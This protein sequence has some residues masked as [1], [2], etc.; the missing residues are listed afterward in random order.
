MKKKKIWALIICIVLFVLASLSVLFL[1]RNGK[2]KTVGEKGTETEANTDENTEVLLSFD[3]YE[4]ITKA[5]L[6]IGNQFGETKI[7]TE[8]AFITE[9]KGSWMIRP[10]GDYG[11]E[12]YYPYF[13]LRCTESSFAKSDFE[14][15]DKL[16]LDVYNDSDE[17]IEMECILSATNA[18]D[19][20][21]SGETTTWTLKPNA[22]TACEYDLSGEEYS[23]ALDLTEARYMN[24]TILS[25]KESKEDTVP[26]LYLDN[27]R[28]H[29]SGE[30]REH[31][32]FACNF[33]ETVTFETVSERYL[34]NA[35][36]VGSNKVSLSRAA[37][38]NSVIGAQ[39][40][41]FG[42]Y[43][44]QGTVQGA[45]W[46]A[47]TM[48]Y[49][50]EL[51][52][53]TIISCKVYVAADEAEFG[54]ATY[55]LEPSGCSVFNGKLKF[56]CWETV[57]FELQKAADSTWFFLNFDD[58]EGSSMFGGTTVTY[59]M[60]NFRILSKPEADFTEGVDL[61]EPDRKSVV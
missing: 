29:I 40:E 59:F 31:E 28:G 17:V 51:P 9:G 10:Q 48:R 16:L 52:A 3:S 11:K 6:K 12:G 60:D 34:F 35:G 5:G 61:E 27:L 46:P 20:Y 26:T 2:N 21:D 19:S 55:Y 1:V 56:N 36:T 57:E 33:R 45:T 7:N 30:T 50:E 43:G 44:L 53:G 8:A 58:G 39:D 22:W 14:A 37:Y 18:F 54:N 23:T 13:R 15:Y 32:E 49:N 25:V 24:V 4:E 38:E 42:E 41:E 47:T